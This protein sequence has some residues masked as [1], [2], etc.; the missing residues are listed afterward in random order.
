MNK[1]TKCTY[2][3][4]VIMNSSE[5]FI[6][7]EHKDHWEQINVQIWNITGKLPINVGRPRINVEFPRAKSHCKQ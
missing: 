2:L 3:L 1:T 5:V 4:Q 6:I 7:I